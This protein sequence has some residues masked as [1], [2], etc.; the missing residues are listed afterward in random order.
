M[1]YYQLIFNRINVIILKE[2]PFISPIAQI[3][4]SWEWEVKVKW[5][6]LTA[7]KTTG[8]THLKSQL[9]CLAHLQKSLKTSGPASLNDTSIEY[10]H[11]EGT[12][13]DLQVLASQSTPPPPLPLCAHNRHYEKIKL[14]NLHCGPTQYTHRHT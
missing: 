4:F 14:R 3:N 2:K 10:L 13:K 9:S 12:L 5:F 11:P 1:L 7:D 6:I 8:V